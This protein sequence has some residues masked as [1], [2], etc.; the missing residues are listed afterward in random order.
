MTTTEKYSSEKFDVLE[1]KIG[2]AVERLT[3]LTAQCRDLEGRNE[4][5]SRE[6]TE[7][8]NSNNELAQKVVDLKAA[9]EAAPKRLMDDQKILHRIDRMIEKFGELQI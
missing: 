4:E 9:A 3:E 5:L 6:L 8:R 7:L 1:A 2:A